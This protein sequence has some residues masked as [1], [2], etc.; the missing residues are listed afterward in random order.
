MEMIDVVR[1]LLGPI[2]PVGESNEDERRLKNL[3]AT[4]EIVDRLLCDIGSAAQ[5]ADRVEHSMRVIGQR[6]KQ[7]L[8]DVS[9]VD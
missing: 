7:F 8:A 6:A 1:R 4:I 3:E 9:T 5:D 2:E